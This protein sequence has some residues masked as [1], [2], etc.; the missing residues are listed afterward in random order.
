MTAFPAPSLFPIAPP[1]KAGKPAKVVIEPCFDQL[2][3]RTW[4]WHWEDE[5]GEAVGN[6][7]WE[8]TFASAYREATGR[9]WVP[10]KSCNPAGTT[11]QCGLFFH[12]GGGRN[13]LMTPVG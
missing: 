2:G 3:F 4:R 9:S 6:A 7:G 8:T 10:E 1:R 12:R 13:W 11:P 5:N